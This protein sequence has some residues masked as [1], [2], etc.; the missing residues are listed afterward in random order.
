MG[1][2][3]V[4]VAPQPKPWMLGATGVLN[5]VAMLHG[6]PLLRDLWPFSRVPGFRGIANIRHIDLPDEDLARL[7]AACG[8]G[9][10]TF[11][12]PNHPEFFTDWMLDKELLWRAAP[13]AASW[14]THTVVNGLGPL[15]QK[16]WLANNLVAQIPGNSEPAR[17][18]SVAWSVK[19]HGVLLHPEGAV[20]W[21]ND[22][23][24]PLMPGAVEMAMAAL[25]AGR[26]KQALFAAIVAP[27]VWKLVF[28]RDA[29]PGLRREAAYVE[30][31]LDIAAPA[32]APTS[33]ER[34]FRIYETLFR[35]EAERHGLAQDGLPL[36]R[37]QAGLADLLRRKL[38][39]TVGFAGDDSAE[40]V[41][42]A[43]RRWLRR[44]GTA[45]AGRHGEVRA[46]SQ[47]LVRLRRLGDFAY[48]NAEITQE[49][50]AE[51]LKRLR[52]DYCKGT[53]RDTL[54]AFMPQPV[55]PR[56]AI[57]RVPETIAVD[58]QADV[59]ATLHALRSRMQA[60]LDG[61][62]A[63]LRAEGAL[64]TLPNP[65]FTATA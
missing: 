54:G 26:E 61:I 55:G 44:E 38:A 5:R 23:V 32:G 16:F 25:A 35:R 58:A 49:Q 60:A 57:V 64:R 9:R 51:H 29:E 28:L 19:G 20:G 45:D 11:I 3:D 40:A 63:E 18:H 65:F 21:H 1:R 8:P 46:L 39:D 13:M 33:A 6:A 52:S 47:D 31:R 17:R 15:M 62:N 56:R 27:V 7:K 37:L 59:E 43:A 10:A 36:R 34:V 41:L 42:R 50:V 14:A 12:V 22:H 2:I 30:R 53:L 48:Q 24:A 4:F